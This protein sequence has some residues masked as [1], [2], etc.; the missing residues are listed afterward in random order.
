MID[1]NV[2]ARSHFTRKVDG[3]TSFETFKRS[4][5]LKDLNL[6]FEY[7]SKSLTSGLS[8][9]FVL[10][11]WGG[12]TNASGEWTIFMSWRC[13]DSKVTQYIHWLWNENSCTCS[14]RRDYSFVG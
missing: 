11:S 8:W 12:Y 3:V 4:V 2:I 13:R 14:N 1:A 9:H 6:P 10:E 5:G 7:E